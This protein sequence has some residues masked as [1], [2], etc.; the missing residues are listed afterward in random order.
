MEA[1][2]KG[3]GSYEVTFSENA[4]NAKKLQLL[5]QSMQI[6]NRRVNETGTREPIIQRQGDSRIVLQVPGLQDPERA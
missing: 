1:S 6:V 4:F 2:D 3:N 5:E